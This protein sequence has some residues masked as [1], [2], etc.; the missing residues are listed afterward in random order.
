LLTKYCKYRRDHRG[1]VATTIDADVEIAK[2]FLSLLRVR[3]RSAAATSVADI[4]AFVASLSARF[5]KKT[6]ACSCSKLRAFLRFL[7]ASG[8]VRR[9]LAAMVALVFGAYRWAVE[10]ED[11]ETTQ[12]I[13]AWAK[14]ASLKLP[15]VP[16]PPSA[17][18]PE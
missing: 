6:V 16:P 8:T 3:G 12:E 5:S 10:N 14:T 9:D 15:K 18:Q 11:A 13:T 17:P 4:D 7:R 1:V 2:A